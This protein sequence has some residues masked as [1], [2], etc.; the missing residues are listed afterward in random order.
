[1]PPATS[2]CGFVRRGRTPSAC[3]QALRAFGAPLFDLTNED[4]LRTDTVFEIGVAPSRIDILT[5]ITGVEFEEAWPRRV[6]VPIGDQAVPVIGLEDLVRNKT[7]MGRPK[8]Q[9]DLIWLRERT[10]K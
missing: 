6:T 7:A 1:V 9:A 3:S 8:D 4:L 5:G 2:T 10:G